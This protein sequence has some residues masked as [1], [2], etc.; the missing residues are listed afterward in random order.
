MLGNSVDSKMFNDTHI[1]FPWSPPPVYIHYISSIVFSDY[2]FTFPKFRPKLQWFDQ[3]KFF[4]FFL[5]FLNE[6]KKTFFLVEL[7]SNSSKLKI[8][9]P[10]R[11]CVF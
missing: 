3:T 1:P 11:V 5:F 4:F 6:T 7:K 9:L 2:L 8:D 10:R